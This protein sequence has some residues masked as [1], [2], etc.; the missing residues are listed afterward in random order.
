[1]NTDN[2]VPTVKVTSSDRAAMWRIAQIA[3]MPLKQR[4][5]ALAKW[6]AEQASQEQPQ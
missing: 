6:E 2:A 1:M 3:A 5:A 4:I